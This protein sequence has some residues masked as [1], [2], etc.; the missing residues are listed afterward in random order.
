L[1]ENGTDAEGWLGRYA[2]GYT[3][4]SVYVY[5]HDEESIGTH[6]TILRGCS[7]FNELLE[8]YLYVNI[9][10]NS[11]PDFTTTMQTEWRFNV[12]NNEDFYTLPDLVDT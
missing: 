4:G 6:R 11:Y 10:S 2:G 3:G 1:Y 8:L 7:N 9:L 5:T 12:S